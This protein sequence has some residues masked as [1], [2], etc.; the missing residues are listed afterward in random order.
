MYKRANDS[1]TNGC[2][3]WD[4]VKLIYLAKYEDKWRDIVKPG[5]NF[6]RS[7]KFVRIF[8]NLRKSELLK[9]ELADICVQFKTRS[10]QRP[11]N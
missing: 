9:K 6:S 1:Y 10:R 3:I 11:Q 2:L 5:R 8:D 4:C 7:V